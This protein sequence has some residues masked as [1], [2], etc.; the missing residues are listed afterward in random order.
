MK[1]GVCYTVGKKIKRGDVHVQRLSAVSGF[2]RRPLVRADFTEPMRNR[3]NTFGRTAT[4]AGAIIAF[5]LGSGFATAQEILQYFVT[6]GRLFLAVIFL[7]LLI[8]AY[9]DYSFLRAGASGK[10]AHSSRIFQYY[11]SKRLGAAFAIFTVLLCYLSFVVMLGG[12]SATLHQQYGAPNGIGAVALCILVVL[13]VTAG[14]NGIVD[15]LSKLGPVIIGLVIFIAVRTIRLDWDGIAA[16]ADLVSEG[17]V[18]VLSV[19]GNPLL[20]ALSYSGFVLLWFAAFM[21]ELG[22]R[23]DKRTVANAIFLGTGI[24]CVALTAVSLALFPHI[25]ELAQVDIPSLVLAR[26]IAPRFGYLFSLVILAGGFTAAVPLLWTAVSRFTREGTLRY[27]LF[28]VCLGC[29]GVG[30]TLFLPYRQL[31]NLV[32]GYSGYAGAAFLF[33]ILLHDL[34]DVWRSKRTPRA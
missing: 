26:K 8:F 9:T 27:K 18:D 11:C 24:I 19:G 2:L 16:G 29:L 12:A 4:F 34:R 32:Y 13:T 6:Y 1:Q 28:A 3:F 10:L 23:N 22:E 15:V 30:A 5:F 14:L 31:V 21:A 20:S 7:A 25:T 17:Q 33:C